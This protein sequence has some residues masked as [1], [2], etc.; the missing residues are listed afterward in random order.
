MRK[1]EIERTSSII[2]A[3][4]RVG[5]VGNLR[6]IGNPPGPESEH[7]RADY[8]SAAGCHPAPQMILI[9]RLN[10]NLNAD[11]FAQAGDVRY[12]VA[13]V[14]GIEGSVPIQPDQPQV[15]VPES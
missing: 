5:Q 4:V 7:L 2:P 1:N 12:V 14:P 13:A 6:R 3:T 15:R 10:K 11:A 9:S 8:Q